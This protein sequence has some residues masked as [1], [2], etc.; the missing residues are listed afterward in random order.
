M[1]SRSIIYLQ[2]IVLAIIINNR[3]YSSSS[4]CS[5]ILE[6][7]FVQSLIEKLL[8]FEYQ[9]MIFYSIDKVEISK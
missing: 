6:T 4:Y 3:R 8:N 9:Y 7:Y 5:K 1:V 2:L